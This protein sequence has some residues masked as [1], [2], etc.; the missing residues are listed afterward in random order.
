MEEHAEMALATLEELR[1]DKLAEIKGNQGHIVSLEDE[2]HMLEGQVKVLEEAI[3]QVKARY[4]KNGV[5]TDQ[6]PALLGK[7]AKMGLT[8][9]ILDVVTTRGAPP[10]L[11]AP[12]IITA[13]ETEGFKNKAKEFYPSV[14]AVAMNMVKRGKIKEGKKDGKRTF[15]RKQSF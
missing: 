10:G 15:M 12:E 5:P 9:A 2:N 14:Y 13:L 6:T 8:D 7:Y 3:S 4:G 11:I 1:D